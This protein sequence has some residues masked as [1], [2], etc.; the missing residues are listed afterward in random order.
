MNG[1]PCLAIKACGTAA[2]LLLQAMLPAAAAQSSPSLS[3]TK[4]AGRL[5]IRMG[6]RPVATYVYEDPAI[7]RPYFCDVKT[8]AGVRVTRNHP[9]DPAENKGNDDH[10]TFH[11]GIWLAFGDLGGQDFWRNKARVRHVKLVEPVVAADGSGRFAVVNRYEPAEGREAPVCEETCVY[12]VRAFPSG[13]SMTASGRFR[14]ETADF[15]FGDQEEMG[16]GIRLNTPLTVKFGSGSMVNSEGGQNEKGTWGKQARW[17]MAS[18]AADGKPASVTLMTAPDNFRPSWFHTRNYGLMVANP[19]GRKA[20]TGP[21]DAAV[22]PDATV[23]K[24]GGEFQLTFGVWVADGAPTA[25]G[26]QDAY[27]KWL[28]FQGQ[29]R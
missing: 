9:P 6:D 26:A 21:E 20:M 17:C 18:G 23:V 27:E 28:V 25:A 15:A 7:P 11:P 5:E 29:D 4:G 19:F 24:K 2:L 22:K 3:F 16:F 8:L 10:A 14:S 13:Y 1:H 12:T